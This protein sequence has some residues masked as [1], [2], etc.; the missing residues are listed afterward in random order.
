MTKQQIL[1]ELDKKVIDE[2]AKI[3]I[4]YLEKQ[5]KKIN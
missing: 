2:F 3:L 1:N 4:S 5:N